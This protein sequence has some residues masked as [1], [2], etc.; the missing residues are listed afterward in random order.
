MY[1]PEKVPM[2]LPELT[3]KLILH[4]DAW[5]LGHKGH[6]DPTLPPT[7][8]HLLMIPREHWEEVINMLTDKDMPP[9]IRE[10]LI[11]CEGVQPVVSIKD[12]GVIL[13]MGDGVYDHPAKL[14]SHIAMHGIRWM[15]HKGL[16]MQI[17]LHEDGELVQNSL[18]LE[19]KMEIKTK[20]DYTPEGTLIHPDPTP[21][22][23]RLANLHALGGIHKI[24]AET[25]AVTKL[26]EYTPEEQRSQRL[27]LQA[28]LA[29]LTSWAENQGYKDQPYVQTAR[30]VVDEVTAAEMEAY[31][32]EEA[33][34]MMKAA[35]KMMG[36]L[37]THFEPG[38]PGG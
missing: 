13:V 15:Y 29:L 10:K 1:P 24:A 38:Q 20:D 8:G 35:Q 2:E 31:T 30:Q 25:M 16:G 11:S 26:R 7:D 28:A 23:K 21:M 3:A 17:I 37:R 12:Q 27:R 36:A 9:H 18:A 14:T 6:I 34:E 19:G 32:P 5:L 33:A 4:Y 22:E